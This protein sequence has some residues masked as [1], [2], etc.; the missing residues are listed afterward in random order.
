[1]NPTEFDLLSAPSAPVPALCIKEC[2][3]PKRLP[4]A[5]P[6]IGYIAPVGERI[7]SVDHRPAL[8]SYPRLPTAGWI[9]GTYV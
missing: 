8:P 2:I 5:T 3:T 7:C 4:F 1:M 6:P 9:I